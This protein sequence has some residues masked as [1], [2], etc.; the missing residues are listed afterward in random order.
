MGKPSL[1][2]TRQSRRIT[3]VRR[4]FIGALIAILLIGGQAPVAIAV[5]VPTL[6]TAQVPLDRNVRNARKQAYERAL[7]T[8]LLRVSGSGLTANA[9]AVRELFPDP[10]AYVMQYRSGANNSLWVSFDG[11]A[12]EDTLRTAGYPVWGA[13]R[14]LTLVWLAVDWGQGTRCLLY[15]SPSPRD[16]NPNLECRH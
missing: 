9:A 11:Q 4:T 15:T 1:A 13:D 2:I 10:G 16:L 14:P 7:T 3:G 6:F 12:I 8:V 5:E